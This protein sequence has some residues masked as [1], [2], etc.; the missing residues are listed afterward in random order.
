MKHISTS[1]NG[2]TFV[3]EMSELV[4]DQGLDVVLSASFLAR[5][6]LDLLGPGGRFLELGK[7]NIL[8]EDEMVQ[9][10]PDMSYFT[11][12]LTSWPLMILAYSGKDV[13]SADRGC[14]VWHGSTIAG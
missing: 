13:D 4:G 8:M 1:R 10:Q 14:Q 6:S 5:E 9:E 12:T 11:Y 2:E 3:S 7:Q